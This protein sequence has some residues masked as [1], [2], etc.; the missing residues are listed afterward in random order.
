MD[1]SRS[2]SVMFFRFCLSS[3]SPIRSEPY[4]SP[5]SSSDSGSC[6]KCG[7]LT[8]GLLQEE[9]EEEEEEEED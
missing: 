4:P 8:F 3:S 9:E 7:S 6:G 1:T 5:S 2:I